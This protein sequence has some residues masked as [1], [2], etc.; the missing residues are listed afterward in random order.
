MEE[1]KATIKEYVIQILPALEDETNI[2]F[3]IDTVVD[4]FL[5]FTNRYQLITQYEEDLED[6][7]VDEDEYVLPI[8]VECE[9][10]LAQVVVQTFRT[11]DLQNTATT[12]AVTRVKDYGQEVTYSEKIQDYFTGSDSRV[13]GSSMELLENFRIP[14]V[15][16]NRSLL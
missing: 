1:I 12:G 8:P 9:R 13:F 14:N 4:R 7:N 2:D 5:I 10:I 6:A 3:I 16:E 11:F 15:V